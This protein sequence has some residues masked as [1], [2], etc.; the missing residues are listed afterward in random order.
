M[1]DRDKATDGVSARFARAV[2]RERERRGLSQ[3]ELAELVDASI[4]H[5]SKLERHVYQPSLEMA[6]RFILTLG[7][8]ANA[9]V[10]ATPTRRNVS[11]ARLASEAE[12]VSMIEAL[13]D[14]TLQIASDVVRVLARA[15]R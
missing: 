10:K 9:L 5:V 1:A 2:K 13:D 12:V 8:D 14:Q 15:K 11:R 7:L 4:D 3:G 6:V